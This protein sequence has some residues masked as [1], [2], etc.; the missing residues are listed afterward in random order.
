METKKVTWRHLK[1]GQKIT[2]TTGGGCIRGFTAYVKEVNAAY[3]TVEMFRI[4]GRE[5]SIPSDVLFEIELT[6]EEIRE[7]YQEEAGRIV[8]AIQNRMT[9]DEIGYKEMNNAWLS[10]DPWEMAMECRKRKLTVLG[11]CRDIPPKHAMFS[12]DLLDIGVCVESESGERFW[13]HFRSRSILKMRN[14]YQRW[15]FQG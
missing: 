1:P 5:E 12:D 15:Q 7:K 4:G 8:E 3:V 10:S 6:E 9:L 2:G 11:H 13:C 14:S